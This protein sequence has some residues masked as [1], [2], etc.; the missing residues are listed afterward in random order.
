MGLFRNSFIVTDIIL[1]V[2]TGF[3][4]IPNFITLIVGRIIQ[5]I[6]VGLFSAIVPLFIN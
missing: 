5:G 4:L 6:C 1:I 3:T 2:G